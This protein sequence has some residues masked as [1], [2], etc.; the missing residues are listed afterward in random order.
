MIRALP[1]GAVFAFLVLTG[2]ADEQPA[3]TETVI[4]LTVQPAPAPKPALKYQLLP[5]LK[6]MNPGNPI[7]GY[8][9]CFCEQ[10]HFFF[11]KTSQ[12]EREKWEEMPLKDLPVKEL[13]HYGG[14]ALLQADFA[15]RLDNPDWQVLPKLKRDGFYTLLPDVQQLRLLG[16]ALK[17]RLRGEIADRRFDDALTTS[18][19]MFALARHLGEHP[20]AIGSLVGIAVGSLTVGPLDEMIA[21]PGSPNLFWALTDLPSP[22]IDFRRGAQGERLTLEV[23]MSAIDT[24]APMTQV[25]LRKVLP[26]LQGLLP[27]VP[28][29]G[30]SDKVL[31]QWL[32]SRLGDE[33]YLQAARRRLVEQGLAEG[34]VKEFPSLQILLLDMA[35]T[36]ASRQDEAL[37][38]M[39]LPFWQSELFLGPSRPKKEIEEKMFD[40]LLRWV[41]T[42]RQARARLQQRLAL[43]CC[44]EALRLHAAAHEGRLPAQFA[45]I[46]LPLPVDPVTG[47]A[48]VYKLEGAT[49]HLRGSPP[50]SQERAALYNV[51]YEVTIARPRE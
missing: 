25:Q 35:K 50:P 37:K 18:Q 45:D 49:A 17:V 1:V 21:Q 2:R 14:Q 4:R 6:E 46:K 30:G 42:T 38:L 32:T 7:Q 26:R 13:R 47:K 44:V 11:H 28:D 16:S 15:A 3:P 40:Y 29:L 39:G 22:L 43:L 8:L 23:E 12:D 34:A 20:T 41:R 9:K 10:N 27:P 24:R 5:E 33:A 51:R 36:Y 48:F 19:T 31:R